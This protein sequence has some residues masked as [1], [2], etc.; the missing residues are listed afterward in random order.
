MRYPTYLRSFLTAL[1][2]LFL[3]VGA[4][5]FDPGARIYPADSMVTLRFRAVS[6]WAKRNFRSVRVGYIRDDRRFTNG[7]EMRERGPRFESLKFK[8]EGDDTIVVTVPLRGEHEHSF[9]FLLPRKKGDRTADM[10]FCSV[11]TLAPDAFG[12]RPFKGEFHQHS[13]LS[14]GRTD[15]RNHVQYARA[16]GLDFVAVTDHR[17]TEQNDIVAAVAKDSG[18]GLVTYRG[19]EMHNVCSILHAV[20]LGAPEAMSIGQRT[21]ELV[22]G[23]EPILRELR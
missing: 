10:R 15:P 2:A 18:C 16:A 13:N 7:R 1:A 11:Y 9:V 17:K 14:D 19:E 4:F 21:P 8:R 6:G 12:L 5:G 3:V 23:A 22:A 20:C